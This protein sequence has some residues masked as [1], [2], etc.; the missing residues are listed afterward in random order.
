[1]SEIKHA[2]VDQY[3][4][5]R[6]YNPDIELEF[7]VARA[8]SAMAVRDAKELVIYGQASQERRTA[9]GDQ[10]S[11][12]AY[13]EAAMQAQS[14]P[15]TAGF[16]GDA[17]HDRIE[18]FSPPPSGTLPSSSSPRHGIPPS[19]SLA[20]PGMRSPPDPSETSEPLDD[21][22]AS[23]SLDY[24]EIFDKTSRLC[25]DGR[26]VRPDNHAVASG[27]YADIW[28]GFLGGQPVAI[29][30]MRPFGSRGGRILKEKLYKVQFLSLSIP[31]EPGC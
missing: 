29:K 25:L 4:T 15:F 18:E 20:R 7:D 14:T 24:H 30:V 28:K 6:Q 8:L 27:G 2:L 22:D 5:W 12:R 1:M 19:S 10:A 23:T 26:I 17:A 31:E 9:R 21:S 11:R 3:E 16:A 13:S